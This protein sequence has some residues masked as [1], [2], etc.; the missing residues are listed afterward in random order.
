MAN[1]D[2]L[3]RAKADTSNY[4]A[5][6]AKAK[7]Q[8][9]NFANAN[10]SA[11]GIL[12]QM[13]GQLVSTAAKFASFG[14]AVGGAMKLAK[15]AF[16]ASEQSL[17]EWGRTV[18]STESLYKGFLNSLNTGDI[19]GYLSNISEITRAA[20]E[21]YNA[22]DELATYNAF[23]RVNMA[24][25]RSG[26]T[27]AVAD[28]REGKGSKDSVQ[29]ASDN[30][31]KE[32]ETRQKMQQEA[33][34]TAIKELA[35]ER[36][37][38]AQ[39]LRAVMTGTYGNYKELKSI[40]LS[41]KSAN[42]WGGGAG[43]GGMFGF[44]G[45]T[46]TKSFAVNEQERLAQAL[47]NINDT[48]LDALQALGE[49]AKMTSV[50]I[51]N[52]RK[53]VARILNGREP[54]TSSG[55]GGG[56][57]TSG[58]G[59]NKV[60]AEKELTPLQKAQKE[61]SS[62]TDEALTADSARLEVIKKEIAALQQEVAY[63]KE[64]EQI[65]TGNLPKLNQRVGVVPEEIARMEATAPAIGANKNAM[66]DKMQAEL[67]AVDTSTFD[68]MLRT[69]V[70]HGI[71]SVDPDLTTIRDKIA[72]GLDIPE[73][74]WQALQNKINEHL[75][76]L[77]IEPINIDFNTGEIK[78]LK[79]EG[80]SIEQAWSGV[81]KSLESAGGALSAFEDPA[82][83][84]A[85]TIAKSLA[86]VAFAFAQSLKGTATPWDFIA[87]VAGGVAAM[88]AAVAAIKSIGKDTGNY[89]DG[90]IIPGNSYSG[91]NMIAHVNSGELILNRAAQSS[92]ASQLQGSGG[93]VGKSEAIVTSDTI[94]LVLR[95]GA[96][97][98]GK[99]ISNYLE[100]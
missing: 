61:I 95:N 92:L 25:A 59:N 69:V 76:S 81:A 10:L 14:A 21:A 99:T 56:G 68:I 57:R 12:K 24:E 73:E 9:D 87:G 33:Y 65:V 19:S 51:N 72:K 45:G 44:A 40:E 3:I 7:K 16:F 89:A 32:L 66:M 37:V 2:F 55:T 26:Y 71:D 28:Y 93:N 94:K 39:D 47:R 60:I 83:N 82:L 70:Q 36:G 35:A 42:T 97:K 58:S 63:Y 8:L 38:D 48:E 22:M 18:A 79:K 46:S 54:G 80:A 15:D 29:Q 75:Q 88:A 100:L 84:V 50:E 53:Q 17:D 98:R 31:I 90:G 30:L 96:Q 62:L 27:E 86:N 43:G 49:T 64:I 5:N 13:S 11:G 23:N 6:I 74:E 91:D 1:S 4:D 85:G 67:A 78:T 41:G 77:G 20:R 34:E 52:Q